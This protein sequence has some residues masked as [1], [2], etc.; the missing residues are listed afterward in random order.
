MESLLGA[1]HCLPLSHMAKSYIWLEEI[2]K[3]I[4]EFS[5]GYMIDPKLNINKAFK[6]K[7]TKCIKTTFG[8]ITQPHISKILENISVCMSVG[9]STEVPKLTHYCVVLFHPRA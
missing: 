4:N 5:I 8:A 3:R 7:V 1:Y 6:E 9:L 2:K